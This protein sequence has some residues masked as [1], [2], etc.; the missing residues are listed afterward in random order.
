MF[1][2]QHVPSF[3][4]QTELTICIYEQFQ[5]CVLSLLTCFAS[6]RPARIPTFQAVFAYVLDDHN[7]A[8][9]KR[10]HSKLTDNI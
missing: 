8:S 5:Y 4:S 7:Y 3:N 10:L 1:H 2:L 6:R 9:E